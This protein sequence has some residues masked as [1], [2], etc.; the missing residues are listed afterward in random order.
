MFH[1]FIHFF[2]LI[3]ALTIGPAPYHLCSL[4]DDHIVIP[5]EESGGRYDNGY[6]EERFHFVL[7]SFIEEFNSDIKKEGG[8]FIS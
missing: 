6:L 7:D 8:L 3:A 4:V 1:R 5:F 2:I